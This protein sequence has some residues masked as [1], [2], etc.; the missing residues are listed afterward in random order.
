[1]VELRA[2]E[3]RL[4]DAIVIRVRNLEVAVGTRSQ[5]LGSID[6]DSTIDTVVHPFQIWVRVLKASIVGRPADLH[7]VGKLAIGCDPTSVDEEA[8][9]NRILKPGVVERIDVD[10][11]LIPMGTESVEVSPL[12]ILMYGPAR[13]G[14]GS[15]SQDSCTNTAETESYESIDEEEWEVMGRASNAVGSRPDSTH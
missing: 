11:R 13:N 4:P 10:V 14:I 5:D 8:V 6:L 3:V 12:N 1:M 2:V 7:V 9:V 15:T